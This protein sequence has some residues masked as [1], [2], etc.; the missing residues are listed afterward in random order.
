MIIQT[1]KK[2]ILF[3]I[4]LLQDR[5][6]LFFFQ[7]CKYEHLTARHYTL[8]HLTAPCCNSGWCASTAAASMETLWAETSFVSRFEAFLPSRSE[9]LESWQ[10]CMAGCEFGNFMDGSKTSEEPW[11]G[12]YAL[13]SLEKR[14]PS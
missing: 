2:M 11:A 9:W 1:D 5:N 7:E 14:F 6:H 10:I 13:E 8:M 12:V 3:Q 4:F